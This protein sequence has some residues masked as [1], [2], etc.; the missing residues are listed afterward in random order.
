MTWGDNTALSS[1]RVSEPPP[2]AAVLEQHLRELLR[3]KLTAC[4]LPRAVLTFDDHGSP[5]HTRCVV[6][7]ADQPGLLHTLSVAF[8][9]AG[10]NVHA[11][12]VTTA[13][14]GAIDTFELTDKN[15]AKLDE[16]A[17]ARLRE[18]VAQGIRARGRRVT[19]PG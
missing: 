6:E 8:A 12:S 5:W 17:K 14:S 18:V 16:A 11:A 13:E 7:A 9:N 15:G 3:S 4:P 1:Y 10:V 19:S 2:D